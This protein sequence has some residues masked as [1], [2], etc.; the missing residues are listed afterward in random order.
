ASAGVHRRRIT[1]AAARRSIAGVRRAA[2]AAI[3]IEWAA[4]CVAAVVVAVSFEVA[5]EETYRRSRA[6]GGRLHAE[7]GGGLALRLDVVT[8]H[9]GL[10][11][12]G[13]ARVDAKGR[14]LA[15]EQK[16]VRVRERLREAVRRAVAQALRGKRR[17]VVRDF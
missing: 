5:E 1:R 16:R 17:L 8:R 2:W 10:D 11:E 4:L 9:V 7:L 15:R 6:G 13:G 14:V 12:A 3:A